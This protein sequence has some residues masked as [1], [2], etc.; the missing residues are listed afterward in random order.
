M[1]KLKKVP[2]YSWCKFEPL[3]IIEDWQLGFYLGNVVKYINRA[4]RKEGE[5]RLTDLKK[6]LFYLDRE[7]KLEILKEK[8]NEKSI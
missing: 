5:S 6:A 2:H 4:G 7:V 3:L 1:R 8:K